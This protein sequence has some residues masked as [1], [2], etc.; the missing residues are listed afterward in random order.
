MA[1]FAYWDGEDRAQIATF[2][3]E[4]TNAFPNFRIYDDRNVLPLME[5]YFPEYVQIY[6]CDSAPGCQM[7]RRETDP[8][9]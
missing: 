6:Q 4:W 1:P 2:S 9:I 8:L 5:R 3:A 7:Q